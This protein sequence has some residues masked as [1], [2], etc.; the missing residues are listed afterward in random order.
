MKQI[1]DWLRDFAHN[2]FLIL[3]AAIL[4]FTIKAIIAYMT[5]KHYDKKISI[6]DNKLN[7]LLKKIQK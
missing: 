7:E 2:Y 3:I 6:L 5:Y 4:F 1:N